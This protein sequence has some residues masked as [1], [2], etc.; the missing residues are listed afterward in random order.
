LF[1]DGGVG[2]KVGDCGG[3]V[4]VQGGDGVGV[5]VQG[6]RHGGVA[7][8]FADNL[9]VYPGLQGQGGVG[10]AQI[11][12]A[13]PGEPCAVEVPLPGMLPQ[14]LYHLRYGQGQRGARL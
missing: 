2:E 1:G 3:G 5:D 10:V 9:G 11:V 8:P 12:K 4:L 14:E 6:H 7:E 13:D